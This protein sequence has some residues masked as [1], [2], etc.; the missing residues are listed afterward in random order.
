[1][2]NLVGVTA[3]VLVA[4]RLAPAFQIAIHV[5]PAGRDTHPGT[6]ALPLASLAASQRS[7]RRFAGREPVTV[8]LHSGVFY[9]PAT[10]QFTAADSGTEA[11]PVVYSAAPGEPPVLS[12]GQRL[13]L[14]WTP[15]RDGIFQAQ[16]PAGFATD[17]LFVNDA[18][19]P[20]ARYPNFDPKERALQRLRGR[21]HQPATRRALGRSA[22]RLHPRHARLALGRHALRITGKDADGKRDLRR[23]LAEQPA[24]GDAPAI[25][26]RGEHLRGTRRARRMVPAMPRTHTLYFYPPAGLDLATATVEAVRLRHL[27]EFRGNEASAGAIR[28]AARA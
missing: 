12:G 17:Q 4:F 9:L 25:P 24:V 27:V 8:W 21:R 23:R 1:M 26:L 15:Y 19:Q 11:L 18:L 10:L 2:R 6:A 20:L 7:A 14:K 3:A 13:T 28:H 16:V 5:S 22:R